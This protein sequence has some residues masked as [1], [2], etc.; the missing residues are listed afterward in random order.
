MSLLWFYF[1]FAERLTTWYGNNGT[2][3]AVFW[4][5]IRQKFAPLFWT[6][7]ICNFIIPVP[8]LAIKRFRT[9]L[10]VSSPPA[11]SSSACGSSAS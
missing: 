11:R 7:V 4:E 9:I 1:T 5:T 2:E 3:M 6:M 8:L 10:G